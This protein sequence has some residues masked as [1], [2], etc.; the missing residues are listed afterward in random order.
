MRCRDVPDGAE[1]PAADLPALTLTSP[2]FA[3]ARG[4]G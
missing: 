3:S 4:L 2:A 1:T